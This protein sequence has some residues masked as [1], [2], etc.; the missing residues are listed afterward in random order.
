MLLIIY[1][2]LIINLNKII[3]MSQAILRTEEDE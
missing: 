2:T 1:N 3:V